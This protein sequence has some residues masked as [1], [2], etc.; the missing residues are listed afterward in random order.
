MW[1]LLALAALL[2]AVQADMYLQNMR[3]SNNRLDEANRDRDNANRCVP[4]VP[5]FFDFVFSFRQ[6]PLRLISRLVLTLLRIGCLIPKTTTVE[7]TTSA[8]CTF[9]KA[10]TSRLSG[11]FFST[12]GLRWSQSVFGNGYVSTLRSLRVHFLT[13][14]GRTNQHGCGNEWND[15]Q[16]VIQYMCSPNLRDG[17]TTNTIP[18]QPSN[19]LNND[20][21]RDI[22]F[23]MHEDY[24]EAHFL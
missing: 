9:T 15:C 7:A 3:G 19:C 5:W 4:I 21:N 10:N 12:F 16:I 2:A 14:H 18:Q 24:G 6:I 17:T 11:A 22:R 23:G 20:C 8:R 1:K 13:W